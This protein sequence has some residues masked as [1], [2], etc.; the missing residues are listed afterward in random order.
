AA[1]PGARSTAASTCRPRTRTAPP[2]AAAARTPPC[3][4]ATPRITCRTTSGRS[5]SPR[6]P[7]P[8]MPVRARSLRSAIRWSRMARRSIP[9]DPANHNYD[10]QA[11]YDSVQAGNFPS[12]TYIKM[13]SVADGHPGNSDPLDEQQ[14]V[15]N[16]VNFLQQQPDWKNTAIVVTYDDSDGWYDH[17]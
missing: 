14:G 6:P 17:D 13:P 4:T 11:F 1:S 16:L 10:L 2:A 8:R 15:V 5:I 3:S 9:P 12:V 7:T